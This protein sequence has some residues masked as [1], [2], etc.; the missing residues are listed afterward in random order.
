MALISVIMP[1]FYKDDVVRQA[2]DMLNKQTR[3]D[4]MEVIM[5]NDC[6]PNTSCE[7][8]NLIQEFSD[9]N[10][11]YLKTESNSGPGVARQ[12]GLD[13][14]DSPWVLFHDD[15]DALNHPYVIEQFL[16]V[17]ENCENRKGILSS[18]CGRHLLGSNLTGGFTGNLF[19]LNLIKYF[20]LSFDPSLSSF[21]EDTYFLLQFQYH[22][23]RLNS[24]YP[25]YLVDLETFENSK[26]IT[27]TKKINNYSI[28]SILQNE[29]RILKSL[30]YLDKVFNFYLSLPR[31]KILEATLKEHFTDL[32]IYLNDL[33]EGYIEIK[34]A[35]D[36]YF[37]LIEHI[38]SQLI[39]LYKY[40]PCAKEEILLEYLDLISQI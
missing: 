12:L 5:I 6:S 7:Y 19:N 8:Q 21:E 26:Y 9:L 17:I 13:N 29:E 38:N 22:T 23:R 35:S 3:K 27:Y 25:C 15:D 20:N 40:C 24:F 11:K 32:I 39:E 37:S 1:C 33:L 30:R 18:I 4:A 31:D 2:L 16:E 28:C 36:E 14:C 34:N 10:I